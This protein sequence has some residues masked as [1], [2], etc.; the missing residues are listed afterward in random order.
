[1]NPQRNNL[2]QT[3]DA[4]LF[5]PEKRQKWIVKNSQLNA[6]SRYMIMKIKK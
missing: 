6:R 3:G 2:P 4:G 1:M 5:L